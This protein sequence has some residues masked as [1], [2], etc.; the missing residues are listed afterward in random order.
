MTGRSA[1]C[2]LELRDRAVRMVA[3]RGGRAKH[4]GCQDGDASGGPRGPANDLSH[5]GRQVAVVIQVR[6]AAAADDRGV[7]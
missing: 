2:P 4:E 6:G 7:S 3:A 1:K 5:Q